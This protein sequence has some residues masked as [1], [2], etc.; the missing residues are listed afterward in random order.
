MER[1][2]KEVVLAYLTAPPQYFA[3]GSE[4][5]HKKLRSGDAVIESR[6]QHGTSRTK[7][8][9]ANHPIANCVAI[10]VL[11]SKRTHLKNTTE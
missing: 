5:K 2:W 9:N 4:K 10:R 11:L 8:R 1:M 3:A 7:N 6:F